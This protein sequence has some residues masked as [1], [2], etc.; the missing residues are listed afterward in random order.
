MQRQPYGKTEQREKISEENKEIQR[1]ASVQTENKTGLPDNLKVGIENLSGLAMDD[2]RVHYNSPKPAELN[3]LAYTQGSDIHVASGEEQHLPHEAWHVVQQTQGRVKPT[4][5]MKDGVEAN[6]EEGMEKEADV[7][8]AKAIQSPKN[9][10]QKLGLKEV[11]PQS[12]PTVQAF[13]WE[14]IW[15][16]AEG[17]GLSSVMVYTAV[18]VVGLSALYLLLKNSKSKEEALLE[19]QKATGEACEETYEKE[20]NGKEEAEKFQEPANLGEL[21]AYINKQQF[22]PYATTN[23]EKRNWAFIIAKKYTRDEKKAQKF[24][25][26]VRNVTERQVLT[27]EPNESYSAPRSAEPI[28]IG[29]NAGRSKTKTRG[30]SANPPANAVQQPMQILPPPGYTLQNDSTGTTA[31]INNP[32]NHQFG[33][34]ALDHI[35][36]VANG[37]STRLHR[38]TK[39]KGTNIPT[40][41]H[42]SDHELY[43]VTLDGQHTDGIGMITVYKIG[44]VRGGEHRFR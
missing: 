29:V 21:R 27:S 13:G 15:S 41:V 34:V 36:S 44:E 43:T 1:K 20:R 14:E 6:H 7:M 28:P 17:F 4:M 33:G 8:G 32:N 37:D 2:V 12:S 3:A 25:Q 11:F 22:P 39:M 16:M 23:G 19:V 10:Y 40:Y 24:V 30:V 26:L 35:V 18:A 31:Y 42:P 5:Q 38:S 9:P